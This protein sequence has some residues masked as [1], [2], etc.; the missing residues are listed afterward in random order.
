MNWGALPVIGLFVLVVIGFALIGNALN[1][2]SSKNE[3]KRLNEIRDAKRRST[4]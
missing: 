3:M 2:W 4:G 1:S